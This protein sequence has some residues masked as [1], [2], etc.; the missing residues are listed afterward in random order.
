MCG[1]SFNSCRRLKLLSL[2]L[3]CFPIAVCAAD[4]VKTEILYEDSL[5]RVV[6]ENRVTLNPH[7][8]SLLVLIVGQQRF[9]WVQGR[10]PYYYKLDG[11]HRIL[12]CLL[13]TGL[14]GDTRTAVL[15]DVRNGRAQ[16][17]ALSQFHWGSMG[18]SGAADLTDNVSERP[19]GKAI[20]TCREFGYREEIE[21]ALDPYRI[22][23]WRKS[24]DGKVFAA[25]P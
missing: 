22:I 9:P 20:L 19:G 14:T 4:L 8:P 23:G 11:G 13:R 3:S 15:Y 18:R 24:R 12:F 2:L 6:R 1:L 17:V 25:G 16:K 5:V 10:K 7:A 21:L